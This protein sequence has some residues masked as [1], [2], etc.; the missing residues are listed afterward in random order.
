MA[1]ERAADASQTAYDVLDEIHWLTVE[2]VDRC[3]RRERQSRTIIARLQ[4][5]VSSKPIDTVINHLCRMTVTNQRICVFI[6][7]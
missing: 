4:R 2:F 7:V 5:S 6:A 3:R 1:G